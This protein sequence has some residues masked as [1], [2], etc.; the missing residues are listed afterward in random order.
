MRFLS[1][2]LLAVT[3]SHPAALRLTAPAA[4]TSE[5]PSE[6]GHARGNVDKF[7]SSETL[8]RE[9]VKLGLAAVSPVAVRLLAD[10]SD[11]AMCRRLRATVQ[12]GAGHYPRTATYFT[13]GGFYFVASTWVVPPG[14]IWIAHKALLV[15]DE[16]LKFLGS[17]AV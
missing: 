17:Y 11:S 1:A 13:A 15:F 16:N 12:L 2:L 3:S 6:A 10:S 7:L 8:S 5:C 14:R 4:V 9:R